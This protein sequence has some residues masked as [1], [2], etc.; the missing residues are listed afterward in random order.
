MK[1]IGIVICNY[2]KKHFLEDCLNS[3]L[4]NDLPESCYD[5]IVVDNASTDG[6]PEMVRSKFGNKI[7]LLE[8]KENLGGS[9][10]F[11]RGIS[12]CDEMKYEYI[13][14]LDNDTKI[15]PYTIKTLKEYLDN[16]PDVGVVGAKILQMDHPDTLLELG[17]FID[18]EKYN[19][20]V[21]YRGYLNGNELPE[22]VDCDYVAAC[23]C[24]TKRNIIK[25]IGN[26]DVRHFIYW[27]DMDWCI[28][29]KKAGYKVHAISKAVVYH[30][31][32]GNNNINT[33][34]TY[35]LIKNRIFFFIKHLN[36]NKID[37]FSK[38]LS[39]DLC[40]VI[41]FSSLKGIYN[42][43]VSQLSAI[44][45]LVRKKYGRVD[46][47][48]FE[49]EKVN[50]FDRINIT[51]DSKILLLLNESAETSSQ[52]YH[53]LKNYFNNISVSFIN[54][55]K[56]NFYINN[57]ISYDEIIGKDFDYVFISEDHLI[58]AQHEKVLFDN[59]ISIDMY[60]NML[61]TKELESLKKAYEYY[62]NIN[63]NINF[64]VLRE[65]VQIIYNNLH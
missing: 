19:F 18:W 38:Q 52:I 56:N 53:F 41:F 35:Y 1:N 30:Q 20:K 40:N 60:Q 50:L 7:I 58:Y 26:F 63:N 11:A 5:I 57:I 51:R 27:D 23:C 36:L 42:P 31:L 32:G 45:D 10:G 49:K 3:V 14:L 13:L 2:N 55:K 34:N 12:Y 46:E 29:I 59:Q 44:E 25:E 54:N 61:F 65:K 22:I 17:A 28:R 47:H 43:A 64:P 8:N 15:E 37:E 9:G 48:V 24:M 33:F 16:N 39:S 6:A 62:K 21:S 4:S